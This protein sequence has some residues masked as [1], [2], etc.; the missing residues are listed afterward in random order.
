MSNLVF[1]YYFHQHF[2]QQVN[3]GYLGVKIYRSTK[4]TLFPQLNQ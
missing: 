3:D 1:A 4:P 2:Q